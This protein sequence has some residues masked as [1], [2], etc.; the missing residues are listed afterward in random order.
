MVNGSG[1]KVNDDDELLSIVFRVYRLS[2]GLLSGKGDNDFMESH[3]EDGEQM[4]TLGTR[5][6]SSHLETLRDD[7][8]GG[9]RG[10]NVGNSIAED[11]K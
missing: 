5:A 4:M 2:S 8:D 9:G 10:L 7:D 3:D 11:I 6:S 1:A